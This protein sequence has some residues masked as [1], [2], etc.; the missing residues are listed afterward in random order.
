MHIHNFINIHPFVLKILSKNPILHQSRAITLLFINKFSPL[1]IPNHST[2][3]SMSMQSLKTIGQKL[4]RFK[5]GNE[6][7]A[8]GR[9]L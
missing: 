7:L 6:A 2:M 3:I 1:A 5:S 4:F 8:D 9:T